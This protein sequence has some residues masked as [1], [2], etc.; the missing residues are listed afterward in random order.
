MLIEHAGN[1]RKIAKAAGMNR[2]NVYKVLRRIDL[3]E[4]R[5]VTPSKAQRRK[6]DR[7]TS[8]GNR[9]NDAWQRLGQMTEKAEGSN[10]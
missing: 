1:V 5:P 7:K 3:L 2:T 6:Y 9:G 10:V 8:R 4:L